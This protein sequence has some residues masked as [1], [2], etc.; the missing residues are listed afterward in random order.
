MEPKQR[1]RLV[2]Y[3]VI[4]FFIFSNIYFQNL[5]INAYIAIFNNTSIQDSN[6][7]LNVF[8]QLLLGIIFAIIIL[9]LL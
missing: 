6:N 2:I 9:L 3:I 4:L 5:F 7:T 1:I 8:G